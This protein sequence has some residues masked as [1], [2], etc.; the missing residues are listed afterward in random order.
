MRCIFSVV[1]HSRHSGTRLTLVPDTEARTSQPVVRELD[2]SILMA[3]A[4]M[5]ERA[6]YRRLLE[7]ITPYLRALAAK[8]HADPRDIEDTVQD[9][10]LTLHAIRHTYDPTRPF[11]PWLVAIAHRRIADRLRR[12]VRRRSRE[13][14]LTLEHETLAAPEAND[15]EAMSEA[16][17]LRRAVDG[18][19]PVQ[20]EAVTLTKLHE[21]SLKQAAATSGMSIAALKVATH[22]A[23][24]SLRKRLTEPGRES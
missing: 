14:E 6:A 24:K 8:C 1:D 3:H 18:L 11:G 7:E 22:R 12:Q 15:S 4:Q 9:V 23:L 13:T 19:P 21:M 16:L 5:G 17:A 20:R 10:L 2:W